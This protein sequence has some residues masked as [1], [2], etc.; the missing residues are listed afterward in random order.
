MCRVAKA[1]REAWLLMPER[2]P[3]QRVV[4]LGLVVLLVV[5]GSVSFNRAARGRYDF[6]HFYLDALYVWEHGELNPNTEPQHSDAERQ[7]PFY[8]PVVALALS[9]I[10]AFGRTPA[11]LI[12]AIGQ[13]AALGFSLR[14]LWGWARRRGNQGAA[15]AAFGVAVLLAVPAFIEAGKFNQLSYFV[16]ALV[17]GAARSLERDRARTAGAL[18]GVAAVLKLLPVLFLPWLLLKRRWSAAVSFVVV[19]AV[20][21]LVPPLAVFG[22]QQ[23]VKHHEEWWGHNVEG[24]SAGGLLNAGLADHFTDRRNQSIT[25]VLARLAW[26]GHPHAAPSQ[27][28][29][30]K[31]ETCIWLGRGVTGILLVVTLWVTRRRWGELSGERRRAE[32]ALYALGMLVFS[33]LFRQYYLVW[34]VP[35]LVLVGQ[36][37]VDEAVASRRL[38]GRL[39]LLVW[40][41]GMLAWI[42]PVT[43]VLGTHLLMVFVLGVVLHWVTSRRCEKVGEV[44]AVATRSTPAG[45]A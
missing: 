34:A 28:V 20:V 18:L 8:L 14:V 11:A 19:G 31:R 24:D 35:A 39:G 44:G 1:S 29:Q 33:P 45:S 27:P 21:A 40:L 5:V 10:T 2:D 22:P 36:A 38:A 7:L 30:L 15:T 13:V 25:Q 37:A 42:W 26:P 41:A 3:Y 9:P 17:L 32:W 16:L 23:A 43:R 6:D 4:G 12:W